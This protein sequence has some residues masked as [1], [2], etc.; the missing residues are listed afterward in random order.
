MLRLTATIFI[1]ISI[2]TAIP[3]YAVKFVEEE[4]VKKQNDVQV[5][6]ATPE[7]EPSRDGNVAK[8]K[9]PQK[10]NDEDETTNAKQVPAK[11]QPSSDKEVKHFKESKKDGADFLIWVFIAAIIFIV[12]KLVK[13]LFRAFG[14]I[15][16][17]YTPHVPTEQ[18]VRKEEMIKKYGKEIGEK[19][20]D[21]EVWVGMDENQLYDSKGIPDDTKEKQTQKKSTT[22]YFYGRHYGA[23][24]AEKFE[25]RV[26]IEN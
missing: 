16:E 1:I 23:R 19:I 6:P 7:K 2:V 25:M 26:T 10:S 3:S 22:T 8:E 17:K 4:I 24:S 20:A 14:R 21:G 18:E 5:V 13:K 12:W 15:G 11:I 9:H